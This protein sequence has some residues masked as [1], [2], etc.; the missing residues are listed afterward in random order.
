MD[1]QSNVSE[2][3][4]VY[5]A[6]GDSLSV[7]IGAILKPGFVKR[8]AKMAELEIGR[9]VI[10]I[11]FAMHGF[12]SQDVVKKL[13]QSV[14]RFTLRQADLITISV[15]GNDLRNAAKKYFKNGDEKLLNRAILQFKRNMDRILFEIALIKK[16]STTPYLIRLVDVYNPFPNRK[17]THVWVQR[18]YAL[19]KSYEQKNVSVTNIYNEFLGKENKLLFLDKLHPNADG[20]QSI[21]LALHKLGY[22][23]LI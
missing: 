22:R 20:Y 13:E 15:G 19:L 3:P 11:N 23:S 1:N 4:L 21:A 2:K 9:K 10:S 16:N 14:V 5:V 7:G 17:D 8:Y 12:T 18:F 6:L